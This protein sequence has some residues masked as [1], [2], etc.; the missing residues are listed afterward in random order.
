MTVTLVEVGPRDGLQA[1]DLVLTVESRIELIRRMAAA[2]ATRIEA[3]SFVHPGR[4]P[5]MAEA[6]AVVAGLDGLAGVSLIGLVLNRRGLERALESD[7]DEI[8]FVVA[9]AEGYNHSN[10]GVPVAETIRS[11]EAMVPEALE[12]GRRVT[13][14]I[15]VAFGDPYDGE[16]AADAVV[17]LAVRAAAA[18]ADEIA[19]GDT[20]GVAVPTQVKGL[21]TSLTNRVPRVPI[22][23]HFHDTRRAGLANV[24]AALEAGI[25][26][27]D[28]SVG[29]LGG[30][31]FAPA[32]GG[33]VATEDAVVFLER[34]GIATGFDVNATLATGRWLG[35]LVGDLP[36]AMQHAAPWPPGSTAATSR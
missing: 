10:Q 9:A 20:I 6:E 28:T 27:F 32:A 24:A 34:M 31:P 36:A 15:S 12:A 33:N 29:G 22:R 35:S 19:L 18:G 11:I 2:G 14:T 17:E 3:A 1:V 23:C 8:N 13:V 21:I 4:V 16:V 26:I 5:Q 25:T 7:V 30:S